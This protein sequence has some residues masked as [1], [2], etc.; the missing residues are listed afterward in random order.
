ML[1][2]P[3][4]ATE[5]GADPKSSD[6][7]IRLGIGGGTRIVRFLPLSMRLFAPGGGDDAY[8]EWTEMVGFLD[9]WRPQWPVL[10]GQDGFM[11]RFTVTMS[12]FA[13]AV[14]VE[15]GDEF[16]RRYGP[17]GRRGGRRMCPAAGGTHGLRGRR[18]AAGRVP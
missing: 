15:D 5:I 6:L 18:A 14:A 10:L 11:K 4:L 13:Q 7:S 3:W 1:A 2:A 16:D 12:R 8:V 9:Q 17:P